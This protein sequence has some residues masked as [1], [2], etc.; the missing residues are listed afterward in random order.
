MI[1]KE[2]LFKIG[3]FAKPH[4]VKGELSL[5]TTSEVLEEVED[6]YVV[7]DIDGIMVPFFIEEFRYKS[8]T[9]VLVKL[10]YV[11][12]EDAARE[13]VNLDVYFPLE[14]VS[15]EELVGE[16]TWD[17]FIGYK[18]YDTKETW[19]GDIT[20]VDETTINVLFELERGEITLLFP[21]AEELIIGLDNEK[22][23]VTVKVP[24]GLLEL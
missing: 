10:E 18:V 12:N 9:V 8:D 4:G 22:K 2:E 14:A 24:E 3:R 16:M 15:E 1:K 13:F 23:Q 6:P 7:C 20:G 17:S 21:A 5:V 11:N 19:I